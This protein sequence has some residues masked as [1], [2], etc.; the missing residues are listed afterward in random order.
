MKTSDHVSDK[1]LNRMMMLK[2]RVVH[3]RLDLSPTE[4]GTMTHYCEHTDVNK[5]PSFR[6]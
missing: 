4:K 1:G 5:P 6:E 2:G 3:G